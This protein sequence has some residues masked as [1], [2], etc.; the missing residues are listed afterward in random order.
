VTPEVAQQA[1][2]QADELVQVKP[3][4]QAL[5]EGAEVSQLV[6]VRPR[7]AITEV[8]DVASE[9]SVVNTPLPGKASLTDIEFKSIILDE[10][11][12]DVIKRLNDDIE[13]DVQYTRGQTLEE[14]VEADSLFRD[15]MEVSDDEL[16]KIVEANSTTIDGGNR[17]LSTQM[18]TATGRF[19]QEAQRQIKDLGYSASNLFAD[20]A[21]EAPK[22]ASRI[23]DRMEA[24]LTLRMQHKRTTSGKLREQNYI[25]EAL[26]EDAGI[27]QRKA[28]ATSQLEQRYADE[29][30]RDAAAI[31]NIRQVRKALLEGDPTAL[32]EMERVANAVSISHPTPENLKRWPT[33]LEALGRDVDGLFIQSIL[34][35]PRTLMRN[36]AGNFYQSFGH[37]LQA[38]IATLNPS[39]P[40]AVRVQAVA[41]IQATHEAYLEMTD[42]I[43]RLWNKHAQH[44]NPEFKEYKLWD[45]D[46]AERMEM[47]KVE[48]DAGRLGWAEQGAYVMA[49]NF[50]KLL[51]SP[52]MS[53]IMRVMGAT[54]SFFKVLAAR[55]VA[56]RRA[57][58]DALDQLGDAPLTP[59]RAEKYAE[60]YE[61]F[62]EEHMKR[63][64]APDGITLLDPEAEELGKVFTFQTEHNDPVTKSLNRLADV[65]LMRTLGLTFI[66][67]PAA[68]LKASANLTPG[69]S[70]LLKNADQAYRNG[71]DFY[72]SM[73]DGAEA[74]SYIIGAT[75]FAGGMSGQITGAGPLRGE[76]RDTWLQTHK[77]YTIN[78]PGGMEINYQGWEPATFVLGLFADM[79]SLALG[80]RSKNENF[81]MAIPGAISS[82][83]VNKSYL[84]QLSALASI[85]TAKDPYDFKKL[86]E[87]IGR[88]LVPFSGLRSQVNEVIDP[89]LREV[90]SQIEP[91]WE[92]F[93][94]KH[95]GFGST[96]NL[97]Q[98]L[99]PV[100]GKEL[101]R[102]GI[103][104][105]LGHFAGLV[106][107]VA[108]FGVR[109]SKN[110]FEAVH[111]FLYN[112]GVDVADMYKKL[113]GQDLTNDEM[114]EYVRLRAAD[115]ELNRQLLNYFYSDQYNKVDKPNSELQ[116]KEGVEASDTYAAQNIKN[117]VRQFHDAAI[118]QME[119]GLT[120]VSRGFRERRQKAI[121]GRAQQENRQN[122][123]SQQLRLEDYPY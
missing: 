33:I 8:G 81:W 90:R 86:G 24:M 61:Q 93:L 30:N 71:D 28:D 44:I 35:G 50:R 97:P 107:M 123:G 95:V 80:S 29:I 13:R 114:T 60:L 89:A 104:G 40:R 92:W 70:T 74:M 103:D 77:P 49:Y 43:P 32:R 67:T 73:R 4:A 5:E 118:A 85:V 94:N 119:L 2:V 109:F 41:A 56:A 121:Q 64:L 105:P 117:I 34:S 16:I 31:Q 112:E 45:Q 18:F 113:G 63:V 55:Q 115:G 11:G 96:K 65:P 3:R 51:E 84:T 19:L 6:N 116:R 98:R 7:N 62:R 75:A 102:D 20:G 42:L 54:D 78:L 69:L 68:I 110:R 99:D 10:D 53:N 83:V 100:I 120:D 66:N 25:G 36:F 23:L 26:G 27:L 106:N 108:P 59:K 57:A 17:I 48:A 46:L 122:A 9:P 87:N 52:F 76:V 22:E 21:P 37:P 38:Y 14:M 47:I 111:K 91:Y 82:N 72:R 39:T 79:G 58:I 1:M 15:F 12:Y 101:T 88:G